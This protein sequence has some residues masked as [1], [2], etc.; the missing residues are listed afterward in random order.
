M[1]N[2]KLLLFGGGMGSGKDTMRE[3]I[4]DALGIEKEFHF[5]F[6]SPLKD[7]CDKIIESLKGGL[8]DK[9]MSQKFNVSEEAV[10]KA[11]KILGDTIE[12]Y[13]KI[14][15]RS[16]TPKTRAFLQYWGTD[17]RRKQDIDYWVNIVRKEVS[18]KLA[19]GYTVIITDGRFNNEFDLINDLNGI[20]ICLNSSVKTRSDRIY[21]RDGIVPTDHALNHASEKDWK[22]YPN[23]TITLD[24]DKQT[25]EETLNEIISKIQ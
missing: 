3:M 17:V 20:T 13:P 4:I 11:K 6:A 25:P 15:S 2:K 12:Y 7:E 19:E 21:S 23:F 24:N 1:K 18:E 8:T 14:N 22:T 9:E 16:R 5:S 10:V